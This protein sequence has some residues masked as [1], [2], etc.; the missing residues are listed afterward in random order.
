MYSNYRKTYFLLWITAEYPISIFK[1]T[2]FVDTFYGELYEFK[3]FSLL[4]SDNFWQWE[5]NFILLNLIYWNFWTMVLK[6]LVSEEFDLWKSAYQ[7]LL[8]FLDCV[9]K[10][11]Q[12]LSTI[13]SPICLIN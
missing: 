11:K 3:G 10:S 2:D 13:V 12:I 7:S 9:V 5:I 6:I 4:I 1:E 8:G